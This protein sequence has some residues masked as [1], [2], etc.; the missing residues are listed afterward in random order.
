MFLSRCPVCGTLRM[1]GYFTA[2]TWWETKCPRS[3]CQCVY[4]YGKP[5]TGV[6]VADEYRCPGTKITQGQPEP[7]RKLFLRGAFGPGSWWE[8]K[9]VRCKSF[10]YHGD[11]APS[12]T[13]VMV[14]R[15]Q[16]DAPVQ[17]APTRTALT[18]VEGHQALLLQGR[19]LFASSLA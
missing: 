19:F 14:Q 6:Y 3:D 17:V 8:V 16:W 9:C 15:V 1:T 5:A 11:A 2:G 7:C 13:A 12:G 4:G 18:R 10:S